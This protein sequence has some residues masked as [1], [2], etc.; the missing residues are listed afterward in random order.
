MIQVGDQNPESLK[1]ERA[2]LFTAGTVIP[3]YRCSLTLP[4]AS[5]APFKAMAWICV[6]LLGPWWTKTRHNKLQRD[7]SVTSTRDMWHVVKLNVTRAQLPSRY[8]SLLDACAQPS[9]IYSPKDHLG[10]TQTSKQTEWLWKL[11]EEHICI[12]WSDQL[13]SCDSLEV[14]LDRL[15]V[16]ELE[17]MLQ[18]Y[19][20]FSFY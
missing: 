20:H 17:I 4:P 9:Y 14:D 19:L 11:Y 18:S 6:Q 2:V 1:L 16:T 3:E 10:Y 15:V 12:V 8:R 13:T 5:L 7:T